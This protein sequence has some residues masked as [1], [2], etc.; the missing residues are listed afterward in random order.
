M[1]LCT[2]FQDFLKKHQLKNTSSKALFDHYFFDL[3]YYLHKDASIENFSHLLNVSPQK[4]DQISAAYYNISFQILLDEHRYQHFLMELEN[5]INAN[6]TFESIIKLCG[7]ASN[8]KFVKYFEQKQ[9]L[10]K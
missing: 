6:M 5:P 10:I 3:K 2:F 7:F 9:E 8:D 4:L 1:S